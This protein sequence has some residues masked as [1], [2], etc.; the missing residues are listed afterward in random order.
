MVSPKPKSIAIFQRHIFTF[1]A[2]LIS[3]NLSNLNHNNINNTVKGLNP[4]VISKV[5]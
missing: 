1:K 2:G 3:D 5:G 4:G